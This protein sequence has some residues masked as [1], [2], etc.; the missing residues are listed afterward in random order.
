MVSP[1]L[2]WLRILGIVYLDVILQEES[3]RKNQYLVQT[4]W[5]QKHCTIQSVGG[6]ELF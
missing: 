3:V 6:D 4:L 5:C 2:Y 1:F